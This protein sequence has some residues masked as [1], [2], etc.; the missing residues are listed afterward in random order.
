MVAKRTRSKT[1]QTQSLRPQTSLIT[2]NKGK[3]SIKVV[4]TTTRTQHRKSANPVLSA[5]K[6]KVTVESPKKSKNKEVDWVDNVVVLKEPLTPAVELGYCLRKAREHLGSVDPALASLMERFGFPTFRKAPNI[7]I[8]LVRSVIYQQLS[9]KACK[10][11]Y[12]RF[13]TLV[14]GSPDIDPE[15]VMPADILR[16]S[17]EELKACGLSA[18]KAEYVQNIARHFKENLG[19]DVAGQ[20]LSSLAESEVKEDLCSI[21][22]VGPWTVDMLLMFSLGHS[23]VLPLGDLGIRKGLATHFGLSGSVGDKQKGRIPDAK[24]EEV[25][26]FW[27]PYRSVACYYM[28]RVIDS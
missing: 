13:L 4:R 10:K 24:F 9:T 16:V 27:R 5:T 3:R 19:D 11:I 22:G 25:T 1:L 21:K 28:W 17:Q 12:D 2:G 26:E 20:H 15:S 14:G 8:A 7:C 6:A 23:D 18:R